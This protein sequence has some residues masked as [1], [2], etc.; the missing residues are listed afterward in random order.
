MEKNK[1]E[2]K[3]LKLGGGGQETEAKKKARHLVEAP[4]PQRENK[5]TWKFS[6]DSFFSLLYIFSIIFTLVNFKKISLLIV[7]NFLGLL[8]VFFI[9]FL[10][11]FFLN[12]GRKSSGGGIFKWL[13]LMKIFD[14]EDD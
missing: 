4:R 1:K 5:K 11:I 2:I 12:R 13:L 9:I 7:E 3:G 8:K 10:G 14:K 6:R